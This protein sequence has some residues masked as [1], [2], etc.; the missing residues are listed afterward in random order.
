MYSIALKYRRHCRSTRKPSSARSAM[1]QPWLT[2]RMERRRTYL[3]SSNLLFLPI[4]QISV[5]FSFDLLG[6]APTNSS[7]NNRIAIGTWVWWHWCCAIRYITYIT[8]TTRPCPGRQIPG[9]FS[10]HPARGIAIRAVDGSGLTYS[11]RLSRA[12]KYTLIVMSQR[13]VQGPQWKVTM[14]K[15]STR[16]LPTKLGYIIRSEGKG[17]TGVSSS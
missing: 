15:F 4:I 12:G 3:T 16:Q 9:E 10:V 13:L 2:Y 8:R 14:H 1:T 6:M 11:G 7:G 17:M 5:D